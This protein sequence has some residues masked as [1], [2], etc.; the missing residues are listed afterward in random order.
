VWERRPDVVVLDVMLP[1]MDGFE[2][3]RQFE[4]EHARVPIVFLT[5]RDAMPDKLRGL[6]T[7]DGDYVTKSFSLEEL[8]ARLR[9]LLRH[10]GGL[11]GDSTKLTSPIS[12]WT[13]TRE[14]RTP[15]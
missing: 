9:S 1:D 5:A 4:A 10:A 8:I 14:N 11:S 13:R 12:R 15:I 7:G 6:T 3:T 2:A